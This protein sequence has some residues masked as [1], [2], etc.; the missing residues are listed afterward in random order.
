MADTNDAMRE[1]LKKAKLIDEKREK[2]ID[3]KAKKEEQKKYE[4]HRREVKDKEYDSEGM[5][6]EEKLKFWMLLGT[7]IPPIIASRPA[8]RIYCRHCGAEGFSVIETITIHEALMK[9]WQE[10][11][12]GFSWMMS[13]EKNDQFLNELREEVKKKFDNIIHKDGCWKCKPIEGELK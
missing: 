10:K 3:A 8:E 11:G 12:E 2:E 1:A 13:Q 9:R 4:A 6:S 5:S 7:T